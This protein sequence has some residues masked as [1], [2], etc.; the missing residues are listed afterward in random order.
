MTICFFFHSRTSDFQ[1]LT[2]ITLHV[3]PI[4]N[5][6]L[7]TGHG[8]TTGQQDIETGMKAIIQE[9]GRTIGSRMGSVVL[10]KLSHGKMFDPIVLLDLTETS[11]VL[12][13][14]TIDA[15]GL[16]IGLGMPSG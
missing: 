9:K 16:T 3:V 2:K 14:N 1:I 5:T 12:F 7:G 8:R 10:G 11:K 13:E 4:T 15:F 6:K